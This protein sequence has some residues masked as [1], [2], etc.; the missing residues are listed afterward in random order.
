MQIQLLYED[1]CPYVGL[2]R[3]AL[4]EAVA[5]LG[6]QAYV[7]EVRVSTEEEARRLGMPGSP[8]VLINGRDIADGG[9]AGLGCRT[10]I[11]V[12]GQ[13]QGWPDKDSISWALEANLEP[14]GCCG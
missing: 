7:E 2:A 13:H 12:S 6:L 10:Y 3:S 1:G 9:E 14:V 8:T 4:S 11:T 5:E